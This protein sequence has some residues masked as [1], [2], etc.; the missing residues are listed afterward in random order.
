MVADA[1][2]CDKSCYPAVE[3]LISMHSGRGYD[4]T[5]T[6]TETA[7]AGW[8][9]LSGG[10]CGLPHDEVRGQ[11]CMGQ[12]LAPDGRDRDMRRGDTSIPQR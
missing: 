10:R 12:R 5:L 8:I 4:I 1:R 3:V 9:F 6:P 2:E 11:Q 7:V